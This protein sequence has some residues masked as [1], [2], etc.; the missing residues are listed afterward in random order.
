MTTDDIKSV[1]IM[2][3]TKDGEVLIG[4]TSDNILIKMIA[5]YVKF[6]KMDRAKFV[7]VSIKDIIE[8]NTE[9]I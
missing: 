4:T 3:E 7:S 6:V 8:T 2:L 9:K 5:S 1:Q